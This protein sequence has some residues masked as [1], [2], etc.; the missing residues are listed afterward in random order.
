EVDTFCSP[1]KQFALLDLALSIYDKGMTLIELGVPVSH[2]QDLPQ[3]AKVR[4]CKS[5]YNSDQV[6]SITDLGR[7]IEDAFEAIRVQYAKQHSDD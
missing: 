4:R 6:S 5:I 2:L 1:Q 3:L 7:E